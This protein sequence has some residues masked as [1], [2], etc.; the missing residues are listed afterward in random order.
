MGISKVYMICNAYES[1]VGHGF[2]MDGLINP[3][4][5][6]TDE[7]EAYDIGYEAGVEQRKEKEKQCPS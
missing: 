5:E 3:H 6:G 2:K 1:G 4:R 7:Y